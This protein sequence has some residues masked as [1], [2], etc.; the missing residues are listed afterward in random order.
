MNSICPKISAV[1][2]LAC[3]TSSMFVGRTS[4]TVQAPASPEMRRPTATDSATATTP[5]SGP[6]LNNPVYPP[7]SFA[8]ASSAGHR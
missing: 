4:A 7:R 3:Q 8:V 2:Y 1:G 5:T 6:M